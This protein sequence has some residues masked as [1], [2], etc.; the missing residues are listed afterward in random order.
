MSFPTVT[1]LIVVSQLFLVFPE[2]R[3]GSF[4]F[5]G[6]GVDLLSLD[7]AFVFATVRNLRSTTV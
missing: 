7:A 3:K 2:C 4:Y 6:L 5:G 1:Y